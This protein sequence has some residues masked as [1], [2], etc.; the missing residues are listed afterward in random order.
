MASTLFLTLC[1]TGLFWFG[2]APWLCMFFG[3]ETLGIVTR[4]G[5][6]VRYFD[7][8]AQ[9]HHVPRLYTRYEYSW[10]I[11]G[12][13]VRVQYLPFAP[14]MSW[15]PDW[16]DG[17]KQRF[18]LV[19]F[20]AFVVAPLTFLWWRNIVRPGVEAL[21]EMRAHRSISGGTPF[22]APQGMTPFFN[23]DRRS[24]HTSPKRQRGRP[25]WRSGLV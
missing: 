6:D 5:V 1:A 16:N 18:L 15:C 7:A 19:L 9:R 10:R 22:G 2:G 3:V 25:C 8:N 11:W 23:S 17:G 24:W 12:D 14:G 20:L 4:D 13:G 21:R